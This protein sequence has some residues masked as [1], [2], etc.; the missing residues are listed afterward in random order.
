[1]AHYSVASIKKHPIL[2]FFSAIWFAE[3]GMNTLYGFNWGRPNSVPSAILYG[4]IFF[5]FAC[6][7]TWLATKWLETDGWKTPTAIARRIIL[8]VPVL[9]CLALSQITGWSVLGITLADGS[10]VRET[11]ATIHA[12]RMQQLDTVKSNRAKLGDQPDPE[13]VKAKIEA[14]FAI[15]IKKE[16]KT[17]GELTNECKEPDWAPTICRE[18]KDLQ[19]QLAA[20][21]SAKELDAAI[22]SKLENTSTTEKVAAGNTETSTIRALTG[23]TDDTIK[24]WL[25]I[26]IVA[27]IGTIATLGLPLAIFAD[28]DIASTMGIKHDTRS[29]RVSSDD[30]H[31]NQRDRSQTSYPS[32]YY[33]APLPS[34]VHHH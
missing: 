30:S 25:S 27:M 6:I 20:A 3:A 29:E 12:T 4:G 14:K 17:V 16:K 15:L 32:P 31:S 11:K 7:G 8:A 23:A 24:F 33:P 28:R 9:A 22:E 13:I 5:S 21:K 34:T 19:S 18:V 1:M 26:F 2:L 10:V